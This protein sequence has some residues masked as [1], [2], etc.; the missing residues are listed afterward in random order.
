MTNLDLAGIDWVICGG[1]SGPGARPMDPDWPRS[2]RDQCADADVPFLFKQ[3]GEWCAPNQM[4][5]Y[6]WR[7]WDFHHGTE[8]V[9]RSDPWRIGKK[10]AGRLLDGVLHD[11]YPADLEGGE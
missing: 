1:E 10:L 11:D 8:A 4:P 3:W 2:V 6:A 7:I 5:D 9:S